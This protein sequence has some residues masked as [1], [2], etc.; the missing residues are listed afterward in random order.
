MSGTQEYSPGEV[1]FSGVAVI[2]IWACKEI[3]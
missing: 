1:L 3:T 2:V